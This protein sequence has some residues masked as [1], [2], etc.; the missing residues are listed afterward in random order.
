MLK[1]ALDSGRMTLLHCH[2]GI[3][4]SVA[5]ALAY[6]LKHTTLDYDK[7]LRGIRAANAACR[8][9]P[10]LSNVVFQAHLERL[11]QT[12]RQ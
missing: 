6:V 9:L 4:R 7:C 12:Y 2:Q 10:A 8:S 1:A 5:A 3:N 11:A